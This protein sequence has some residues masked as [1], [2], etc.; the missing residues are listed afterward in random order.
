MDER[1]AYKLF[2]RD[3]S[4]RTL[5]KE[6]G[7][8]SYIEYNNTPV[9]TVRAMGVVVSRYDTEGYTILTLDDSTETVSV[10]AFGEDKRLL[11]AVALGVTV[12]VVGTLREYEGEV[13]IAPRSVWIVEDPNWE[14][15]R[16]LE[17]LIRARK[18]GATVKKEEVLD[19]EEAQEDLKPV[20]LGLIEKLDPGDGADYKSLLKQSGLEDAEF[21]QVLNDLLSN[22]DIYEPKIGKFKRI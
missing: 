8:L 18:S 12:D 7:R 22:S 13:Y 6:E 2:I 10:R 5:N 17:L 16:T 15:A 3:I 4:E 19:V 20:V 1:T 11:E 21:D 9:S 14:V